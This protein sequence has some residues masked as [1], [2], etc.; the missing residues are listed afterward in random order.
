MIFDEDNF[1][2]SNTY[3][4][5]HSHVKTTLLEAWHKG[6]QK[7]ATAETDLSAKQ[8]FASLGKF[9][10]PPL[11]IAAPATP[12]STSQTASPSVIP[13]AATD[14]P[15][16][17]SQQITTTSQSEASPTITQPQQQNTTAVMN[18]SPERTSDFDC[19]SI[20]DILH[21]LPASSDSGPSYPASLDSNLQSSVTANSHSMISRAKAGISKPNK[22]YA[23][24]THKTSYP[25]PTTVT[26]AMKDPGW[27]SA[28]N[29]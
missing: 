6:F 17:S 5:L 7:P 21:S 16:I 27:N 18:V 1:L 8:W 29:E 4:N 28:I 10:S 23:L 12:N 25:E 20:S 11:N 13:A 14:T 9:Q 22:R 2:F 3:S 15:V 26:E 24:L 19:G